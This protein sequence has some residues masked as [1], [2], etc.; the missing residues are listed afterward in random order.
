MDETWVHHFQATIETVETLRFCTSK[1]ILYCDVRRQGDDL[2]FLGC[3]RAVG[4]LPRHVLHYHRN[5]VF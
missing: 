3:R 4:G 1:E 5:L 2:H